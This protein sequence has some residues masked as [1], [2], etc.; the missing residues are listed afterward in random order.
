MLYK[1]EIILFCRSLSFL[2]ASV[3]IYE[4]LSPI[5]FN[6][7]R[8]QFSLRIAI[9]TLPYCFGVILYLGQYVYSLAFADL[10]VL[11]YIDAASAWWYILA[12]QSPDFRLLR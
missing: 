7:K 4:L 3:L 6:C 9:I 1:K 11:Y 5:R 8:F 10:D 2:L 12:V